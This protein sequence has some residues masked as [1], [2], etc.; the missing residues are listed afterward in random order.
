M[1]DRREPGSVA[2]TTHHGAGA[3]A[4]RLPFPASAFSARAEDL[5]HRI[6]HDGDDD[7]EDLVR[8]HDRGAIRD[9]TSEDASDSL[10]SMIFLFSI[11][12]SINLIR[13]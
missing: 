5:V 10:A 13:P 7:V 2:V 8:D 9:R 11:K 1:V 4:T 12:L 6:A 3:P